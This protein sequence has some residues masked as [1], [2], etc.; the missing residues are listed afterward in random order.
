[1]HNPYS[2]AATAS[3]GLAIQEGACVCVEYPKKV[4]CFGR[5][6]LTRMEGFMHAYVKSRL[7]V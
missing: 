3:G 1:M 2:H 6:L 7:N 5:R 4:N